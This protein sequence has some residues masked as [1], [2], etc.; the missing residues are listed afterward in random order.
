MSANFTIPASVDE[1]IKNFDQAKEPFTIGD[2][3]Q[4]LSK[5]RNG[6]HDPGEAEN[7]GSWAEVCA[8][9]LTS[10]NS[11]ESPWGTYFGPMGSW[12][13]DTS[14]TTYC[15]DIVH[16]NAE[17]LAHW[18]KRARDVRNPILKSRYADLVWDLAYPVAQ[19]SRDPEMARSAID[20]YLSAS[21]PSLVVEMYDRFEVVI[22][23]FDLACQLNDSGR[24]VVAR[25]LLIQLHYEAVATKKLW[26]R[27]FDR[28]I[29]EKKAG[30]DDQIRN[31]LATSLENL[32]SHFGD[33]SNPSK[34]NPHDLEGVANRLIR[35]YQRLRKSDEAQRLHASVAK[36]FE[37]VAGMADP[38][39][40][41]SF[42]QTAVNAYR[43][44][45][46]SDDSKRLRRLMEE[47]IEQSRESMGIVETQTAVSKEDIE[48]FCASI[49]DDNIP[50][51][52]V[53][54]AAEFLI[55]KSD[56]ERQIRE[57][58]EEAP[59]MA[60]MPMDLIA[61]ERVVARIGPIDQDLFG[62]L[63]NHANT[64]L[65]LSELWLAH[66]FETLLEVHDVLPEHIVAWANRH[67]IFEDQTLLL[68]GIRAW[69]GGD[70]VKA[71]HVLVPQV[72]RGLRGIVDKLEQPTTKP[73][74]K[75]E[76]ASVA[77]TMGDVLNSGPITEALGPD[78]S[79]H[80]LTLYADPRGKNLRN[81]LAHG[82]INPSAIDEHL[83]HLIIHTLLV[84]G[85]WKEL[86]EK[87]R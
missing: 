32:V 36:A 47:R 39:L 45:G 48:K 67:G 59:L 25:D 17:V 40:A 5:A 50:S 1:V 15:P 82:L 54:I 78:L 65:N 37:Y 62:R 4:E 44:A 72:E 85:L 38:M 20:A 41:S 30:V 42:L 64:S 24:A 34:F 26:W 86:A 66:A 81:E 76:G 70:N 18:A 75:V 22:R 53:R 80:F 43:N 69:Y 29:Q 74:P 31:D 61:D 71:V 46:M 49:V 63:V 87:R 9:A 23:A 13:D 12:S 73:H 8:F 21:D 68:E 3:H 14:K 57:I 83:V 84:F 33:L 58:A 27:G 56:C 79:I 60:H 52:F 6:L 77:L 10:R 2:V 11:G 55:S 7:L 28:L 16:A 51:S 19:S 35:Y